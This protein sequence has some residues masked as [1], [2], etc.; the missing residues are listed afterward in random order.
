[1]TKK[2]E[3]ILDQEGDK[4][5]DIIL[6]Q[7]KYKE[8]SDQ[9]LEV[10][11]ANDENFNKEIN[12]LEKTVEEEFRKAQQYIDDSMEEVVGSKGV[13]SEDIIEAQKSGKIAENELDSTYQEVN[14][15]LLKLR[16]EAEMEKVQK[17]SLEKKKKWYEGMANLGFRISET[18]NK[19]LGAMMEGLAGYSKKSKALNGFFSSY[20]EI[21]NKSAKNDRKMMDTKGKGIISS[22]SGVAR[23]AGNLFKYGRVLYDLAGTGSLRRLNPFRHV[24]AAAMFFGR[25]SEAAKE[26]RF[27]SEEVLENTRVQDLD[28]ARE[29]AMAVY[30]KAKSEGEEKPSAEDLEK[31]YKENLP[32]DIQKRFARMDLPMTEWYKFY[33]NKSEATKSYADRLMKKIQKIENN[34]KLSKKEK[35]IKRKELLARNEALLSD[36]DKMVGDAGTVDTLAYSSRVLE[37]GSKGVANVLII[38]SLRMMAQSVWNVHNLLDSNEGE[39]GDVGADSEPEI[40]E[41]EIPKVLPVVSEIPEESVA[42]TSPEESATKIS[43]TE[44]TSPELQ[45]SKKSPLFQT[46]KDLFDMEEKNNKLFDEANDKADE[47]EKF[48]ISEPEYGL[49]REF[50][51]KLGENKVPAQLERVFHMM[52]VDSMDKEKVLSMEGIEGS[53]AG[54]NM[55]TEEQGAKSL[56]VAANLVA[57]SK[58]QDMLGLKHEDIEKIFKVNWEGGKAQSLE[59]KN[60]EEFNKLVSKLNKH[61]DELWQKGILKDEAVGYLGKIKGEISENIVHASGLEKEIEG[62]DNIDSEHIKDFEHSKMV[63]EAEERIHKH[64]DHVDKILKSDS[65]NDQLF[66]ELREKGLVPNLP[67]END[68]QEKVLEDIHNAGLKAEDYG[69]I[70]DMSTKDFLSMSS[71]E[72]AN[73][74]SDFRAEHDGHILFHDELYDN[75]D[76]PEHDPY[77]TDINAVRKLQEELRSV[78]SDESGDKSV[79]DVLGEKVVGESGGGMTEKVVVAGEVGT[80]NEKKSEIIKTILE[81][82]PRAF[83]T[84]DKNF[85]K[86]IDTQFNNYYNNNPKDLSL[87]INRLLWNTNLETNEVAEN[88]EVYLEAKTGHNISPTN[89]TALKNICHDLKLGNLGEKD[90]ALNYLTE[91]IKSAKDGELAGSQ[92]DENKWT[93]QTG[94]DLGGPLYKI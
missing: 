87:G 43:D 68:I 21:Y 25:S 91:Y 63:Q 22:G 62:Y 79:G 82:R 37:K 49:K 35:E 58:G 4:E 32:E 19:T 27:K 12:D 10:E 8:V 66:K 92:V 85:L 24:T 14:E 70:K 1:M 39:S 65:P 57:L 9:G 94:E 36:L 5:G 78:S 90:Q 28:R 47:L 74:I 2:E 41:S 88:L 67:G 20:A 83:N 6:E 44:T 46:P 38:D 26:A 42:E 45:V 40:S 76:K 7:D 81:N 60:H 61:A 17:M 33:W 59:I 18:K 86:E 31:A 80:G 48:S 54:I 53:S 93:T 13:D 29:E 3:I 89:L 75:P 72:I 77:K 55:F 50:I 51:L 52:A 30:E 16:A 34:K 71:N 23:G 15:E 73:K 69:A 56:N 84:L 64:F 11:G